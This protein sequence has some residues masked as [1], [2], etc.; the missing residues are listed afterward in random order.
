[1]KT[2][3]DHLPAAKRE[4]I[5]AIAALL[6]AGAPIEL[7][8]LFGSYARGDWVED[9]A[10]SYFSDY[11]L[12]VIVANK[13]IAE[14]DQL[15]A[16]LSKEAAAIAGRIPV[17][18]L[19]HDIKYINREIRTGQYFFSD[20]VNE[21]VVL[22]DSRRVML[23]KPKALNAG[24]R[25]ELAKKNFRYWFESAGGFLQ[26]SVY[27]ATRKMRPHAAFLLHQAAERYFHAA[28]LVFTGYKPKTHD[29]ESLADQTAPLHPVLAGALPRSDPEDERLFKLLK[30]A[31]IE[32]RYNKSYRVTDDEL[33]ILRVR[34]L[35]LGAR[36]REA[37]VEKL[38]TFC[39]SDAVGELPPLVSIE[40]A[41]ELPEP[42]PL[43]DPKAFDR[44]RDAVATFNF[45]RGLREGELRGRARALVDVLRQRGLELTDTEA[46]QILRCRDE[47]L[48]ASYWRHAFSVTSV[49]DLFE[50]GSV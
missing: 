17:T 7:L 1:M 44:W 33:S 26:G 45:E 31:Y 29:L 2:G 12:M 5:T 25:L 14:N 10:T 47:T 42:P 36:V 43:D 9:L 48:L 23:A 46:E 21:G 24:E 11:D 34:V 20:V 22:F 50:R 38:A 27:Y 8:L 16:R 4:Q 39:G 37:C 6:S 19:V 30:R 13:D 49:T 32:A 40:S 15:W 28:L 35:D 3:L 41:L 18:L